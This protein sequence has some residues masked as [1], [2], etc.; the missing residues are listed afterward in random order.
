MPMRPMRSGVHLRPRHQVVDARLGGHFVVRPRGNALDVHGRAPSGRV[1]QQQRPAVLQHLPAAEEDLLGEGVG[2]ADEEDRGPLAGGRVLGVAEVAVVL[3]VAAA[4]GDHLHGRLVQR[5]GRAEVR[6]AHLEPLRPD[7]V[8]LDGEKR[9]GH[10]VVLVRVE[11]ELHGGVFVPLG[12]RLPGQVL[13]PPGHVEPGALPALLV[14]GLDVAA[15]PRDVEDVAAP[16]LGFGH[17]SKG[18]RAHDVVGEEKVDHD[19][20]V[21]PPAQGLSGRLRSRGRAGPFWFTYGSP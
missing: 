4:H 6:L 2:A 1:Y 8:L 14:A 11:E 15:Q 17:E 13:G 19:V 9:V 3:L 16:L 12:Q 5:R 7:V 10:A 21:G 20:S 18:M